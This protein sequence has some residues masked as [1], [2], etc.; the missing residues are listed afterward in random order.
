VPEF[1]DI[2]L[3]PAQGGEASPILIPGLERSVCWSPDSRA[4]MLTHDDGED[5]Y[6]MLVLLEL[7]EVIPIDLEGWGDYCDWTN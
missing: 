6:L 4:L 5:L 3:V 1:S 7:M 2:W